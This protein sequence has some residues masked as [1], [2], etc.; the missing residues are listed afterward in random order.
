MP[1]PTKTPG[2]PRRSEMKELI[3]HAALLGV[4]V[5]VAHIDGPQRGFY[6]SA[7]KIVVYDFELTPVEQ[8][9]VLAHELGHAFYDHQCHGNAKFEAAADYYAACLL[10]SP[11]AYV[12]AE[13][14]D[15]CPDA[16]AEAL[17]VEPKL[18]RAF[19]TRA[20]TRVHGATYV[21]ARMG[22]RQYAWK[23]A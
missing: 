13:R 8:R 5:H 11:E 9:S 4:S 23:S 17:E 18:V 6:D 2:L 15:P 10:I 19:E 1:P 12:N 22:A 16:I 3:A 21:R 14:I 7:K 20:L